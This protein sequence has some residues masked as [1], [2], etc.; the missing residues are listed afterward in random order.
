M[1][2]NIPVLDSADWTKEYFDDTLRDL[3]TDSQSA[4]MQ[5]SGGLHPGLIAW[6]RKRIS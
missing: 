4:A 5:P 3:I 2:E 1:Q 6:P